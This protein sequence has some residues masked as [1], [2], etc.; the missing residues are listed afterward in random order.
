MKISTNTEI[1]IDGHQLTISD[2][3]STSMTE[4]EIKLRNYGSLPTTSQPV[5]ALL[6]PAHGGSAIYGVNPK[7][8]I[9]AWLMNAGAEKE[10]KDG[11]WWYLAH[12]EIAVFAKCD[13]WQSF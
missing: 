7:L 3:L 10:N 5:L 4:I 13:W 9:I 8:P 11:A 6:A 1:V 12:R 2:F